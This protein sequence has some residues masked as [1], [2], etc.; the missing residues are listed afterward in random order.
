MLVLGLRKLPLTYAVLNVQTVFP[1]AA[2]VEGISIPFISA[3]AEATV[4]FTTA[5][6]TPLACLLTGAAVLFS[7]VVLMKAQCTAHT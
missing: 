2:Q 6:F 3:R 5:A 7:L 4:L 1:Q